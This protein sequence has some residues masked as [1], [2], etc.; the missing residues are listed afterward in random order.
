MSALSDQ[1]VAGLEKLGA[2]AYRLEM[3]A[4]NVNVPADVRG[5]VADIASRQAQ[6]IDA[7][8]TLARTVP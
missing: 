8:R 5:Q 2:D 1:L 3:I 6:Q 4:L 7:L